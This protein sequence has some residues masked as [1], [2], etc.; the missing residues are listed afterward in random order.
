[1]E[2]EPSCDLVGRDEEYPP[3]ES[4]GAYGK[5]LAVVHR[6]DV[7][8]EAQAAA[9]TI[10]AKALA[11]AE[12]GVAIEGGFRFRRRA[13]PGPSDATCRSQLVLDRASRARHPCAPD[14]GG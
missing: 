10:D 8:D 3:S 2:S 6:D 14:S 9:R 11:V 1:V 5:H 4:I 13:V 12:P 7:V